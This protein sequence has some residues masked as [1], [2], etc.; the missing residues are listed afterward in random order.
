M[1]RFFNNHSMTDKAN[2]KKA[3]EF[4]DIENFIDYYIA[5]I[6]SANAD[7]PGNNNAF[8]R[9]KPDN[10]GYDDSAV[11]YQDG[12][13]RW[14]LKDMDWGF[15]LMIN[16]TH[17]TLL[18]AMSENVGG[19]RG[20]GGGPGGGFSSAET[21]LMFRKLLENEEFRAKFINR[22][23]DVMNTNYEMQ[24]VINTINE[25]QASIAP[26]IPEQAI[27]FPSSVRN[28][29]SWEASVERMRQFASERTGYIRGFLQSRFALSNIVPVTLK[30]DPSSGYVRIN[31]TNIT[32]GTRGVYD[33]SLWSGNYFSGTTQTLT[34]VPSKGSKFVRFVV[35]D[36]ASN[37]VT[38]HH[39][40][41]IDIKLGSEGTIVEA[42]FE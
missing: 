21:T 6:Y 10:V 18:H 4:L 37:T 29:S 11:W 13:F 16:Q 39:N 3:Q 32:S 42:V 40:S 31:N 5:N 9:Y 24:T 38:E 25:M 2:Y 23:C 12:R 22:F 36:T 15:G 20:M 19:G 27:R 34:A 30:T 26:A 14:I 28:V 7:W 35:T 33:P 8:W 17:N 41:K 1:I